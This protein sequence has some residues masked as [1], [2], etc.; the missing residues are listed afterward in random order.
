M[1]NLLLGSGSHRVEL[2]AGFFAYVGEDIDNDLEDQTGFTATAG[3]RYQRRGRV[4]LRA[5]F[6]PM[7]TADVFLPWFGFSAGFTWGR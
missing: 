1:A 6:T 7:V 2:G 4:F 5:A 3:Y